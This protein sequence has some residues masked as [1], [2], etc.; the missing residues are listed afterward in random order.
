MG[1]VTVEADS[2]L[3]ADVC[4]K[5][6]GETY[7]VTKSKFSK[8]PQGLSKNECNAHIRELYADLGTKKK[9]SVFFYGET[10]SNGSS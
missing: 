5:K 9:I 1:C 10:A 6:Q 8:Y 2:F 3:A 7:R 4:F